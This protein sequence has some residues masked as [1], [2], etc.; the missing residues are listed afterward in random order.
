PYMGG[1]PRTRPMGQ[2]CPLSTRPLPTPK[3]R[4]ADI[5]DMNI[6]EVQIQHGRPLKIP[7]PVLKTG[8][9]DWPLAVDWRLLMRLLNY[10][11]P[12]MRLLLP[13]T[14]TGEVIGFSK[15][16]LKGSVSFSIL[17]RCRIPR[18]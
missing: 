13:V 12:G 18:K 3:I 15:Q 2:L 4:R 9:M 1:R 16:S 8:I 11:A 17:L 10:W 14:C 6:P 5:G 7:W